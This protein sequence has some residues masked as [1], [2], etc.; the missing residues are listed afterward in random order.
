LGK[1]I[2]QEKKE[3][4]RYASFGGKQQQVV[5]FWWEKWGDYF[6][7]EG[8]IKRKKKLSCKLVDNYK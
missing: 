3:D 8:T 1:N 7:L 6:F 5:L 4:Y 2:D